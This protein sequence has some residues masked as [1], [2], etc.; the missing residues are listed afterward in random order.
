VQK[1]E[2][3]SRRFASLEKGQL[4]ETLS[5]EDA[6]RLLSLPRKVGEYEGVDVIAT[7]GKFGPYLK[8]GGTNITLPKKVN[9][10]TVDLQTCIEAINSQKAAAPE[11]NT[12][13]EFHG[14]DIAIINGRYGPYIKHAGKNFRIPKG[15][16]AETL[17]LEQCKKLITSKK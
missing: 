17:D 10:L 1:G 4:I 12:I 9:P 7:K 6:I 13:K 11:N 2:G 5:L 15:T 16:K 3:E 14:E 8:Y